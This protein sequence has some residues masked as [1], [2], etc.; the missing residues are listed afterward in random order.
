[1]LK[2]DLR[3]KVE[4][5]KSYP[6]SRFVIHAEYSKNGVIPENKAV[7]SIKADS[8][9]DQLLS[10]GVP[11]YSIEKKLEAKENGKTGRVNV[12]VLKR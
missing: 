6:N 10:L 2:S 3:R 8:V 5:L 12:Q 11:Q 1:K 4:I 7:A 9:Q